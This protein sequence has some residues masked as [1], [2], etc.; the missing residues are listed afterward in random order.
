VNGSPGLGEPGEER[1]RLRLRWQCRRGM[2]ELDLLLNRF[3]DTGFAALDAGQRVAFNRLLAYQD[4]ILYDWLMGH[5]VP[6]D[7]AMRDLAGRVRAAML[8]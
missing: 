4:Q 5:A 6:A 3:L 1:E 2:L 7:A 8:A